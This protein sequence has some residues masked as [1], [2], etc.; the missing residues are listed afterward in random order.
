LT[1]GVDGSVWSLSCEDDGTGNF[2][3]YK[4]DPFR[5]SWYRVNGKT[6]VKI[7]SFNEVSCAVLTKS[8]QIFFSSDNGQ[9]SVAEYAKPPIVDT[10][11]NGSYILLNQNE[12][13]WMEKTIKEANSTANPVLI[14]RSSRDG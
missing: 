4:W 14:F 13:N 8:G 1:V 9:R 10:S 5:L 2:F 12:R 11:L 6:G 7:A 3:L